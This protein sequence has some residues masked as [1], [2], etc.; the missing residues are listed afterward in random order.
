MLLQEPPA[1]ETF[2]VFAPAPVEIVAANEP[3]VLKA[4]R[5]L[6]PA[7]FLSL[8]LHGGLMFGTMSTRLPGSGGWQII[9][10]DGPVINIEVLQRPQWHATDAIPFVS[11][12]DP[13]GLAPQI[14]D[15]RPGHPIKVEDDGRAMVNAVE[16]VFTEVQQILWTTNKVM[17]VWCFDQSPTIEPERRRLASEID[18]LYSQFDMQVKSTSESGSGANPQEGSDGNVIFTGKGGNLLPPDAVVSSVMYFSDTTELQTPTPTIDK[19]KIKKAIRTIPTVDSGRRRVCRAVIEGVLKHKQFKQFNISQADVDKQRKSEDT[20]ELSDE[21]KA[22]QAALIKKLNDIFIGERRMIFILVTDEEGDIRENYKFLDEAV[23]VAIDQNCRIYVLGREAVFGHPYAPAQEATAAEKATGLHVEVG[24]ETARPEVLQTDGLGKRV[25]FYPA[26]FGPYEQSRLAYET[27][28]IFFM[29]PP[30]AEV[31]DNEQGI[32]FDEEKVLERNERMVAS[33]PYLPSLVSREEYDEQLEASEFRMTMRMI[34]DQLN[35]GDVLEFDDNTSDVLLDDEKVIVRGQIPE[36]YE[37]QLRYDFPYERGEFM[38]V[39]NVPYREAERLF[40]RYR[41]LLQWLHS[42]E[43]LRADE[44]QMRWRA[45]YDL[46]RAEI[47]VLQARLYEYGVLLKRAREEQHPAW[48]QGA[49]RIKLIEFPE[50]ETW[51]GAGSQSLIYTREAKDLLRKVVR[52]HPKTVWA[53]RAQAELDRGFGI[54]LVV[55]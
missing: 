4:T 49:T 12:I 35:P 15:E 36:G 6:M 32:W 40:I 28:G 48:K 30:A 5:Y 47:A 42:I 9:E 20:E 45:N 29:C 41:K 46:L 21:A 27:G 2:E 39:S 53:L 26:G 50:D 38:Q 51:Y 8:V 18:S 17:I 19:R 34:I 13:P 24:T 55:Y 31:F 37:V 10:E 33:R 25:D 43:H 7:V 22:Q 23:N 54:K 44:T 52:E 14:G 3:I 16:R 1:A 11:Q